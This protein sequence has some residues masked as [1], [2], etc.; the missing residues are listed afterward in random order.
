MNVSVSTVGAVAVSVDANASD[1]IFLDGVALDD[2]D[3]ITNLSTSGDVA[4]LTYYSADGWYAST[5]SWTDG[6]A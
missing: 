1:K 6:G 3:K 4:V 2:G 5:N